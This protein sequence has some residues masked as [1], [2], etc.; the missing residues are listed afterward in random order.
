M[1]RLLFFIFIFA[2]VTVCKA[3]NDKFDIDSMAEFAY[4]SFS[5]K[6]VS[7]SSISIGLIPAIEYSYED[8]LSDNTSLIFR[9]GLPSHMRWTTSVDESGVFR[10]VGLNDFALGIT[11][12]PRYY[13]GLT[14]RSRR[15]R[16]TFLNSSN[17]IS[18]ITSASF[19]AYGRFD[20]R[21][22]PA[23][24]MRRVLGSGWMFEF[25]GGIGV[26]L[27]EMS[28]LYMFPSLQL[29]IG[30]CFQI[31]PFRTRYRYYYSNFE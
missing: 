25:Y 28:R 6:V 11:L 10:I 30:Y 29:R 3:Q 19:D 16:D 23:F 14:E 8:A 2:G 9:A 12:E 20:L 4:G 31:L 13:L 17:Y 15:G 27:E 18:L 5:S 1:K 24:G 22:A 21:A 26:G 7:N